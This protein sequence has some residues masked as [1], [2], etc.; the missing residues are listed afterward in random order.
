MSEANNITFALAKT[1]FTHYTQQARKCEKTDEIFSSVFGFEIKLLYG[2][3]PSGA[4]F[5]PK[6][7]R[8]A[9]DR[10]SGKI[11]GC[12]STAHGCPAL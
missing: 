4:F 9:S 6:T 10:V 3:Y 8:I 12:L 7:K 1:S 11:L 2:R 5:V